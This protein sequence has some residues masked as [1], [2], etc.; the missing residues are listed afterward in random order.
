MKQLKLSTRQNKQIY[1]RQSV[2]RLAKI[3][4]IANATMA[5]YLS[6]LKLKPD[7]IITL[8]DESI[9]PRQRREI[10]YK[11]VTTESQEVKADL[12]WSA[13]MENEIEGR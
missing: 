11:N 2:I 10:L 8:L 12:I 3:C 5:N 9:K 6:R 7:I 4:N 1:Y 13:I